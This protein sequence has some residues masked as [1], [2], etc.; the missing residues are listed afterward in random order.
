MTDLTIQQ[1]INLIKRDLDTVKNPRILEQILD[2]LGYGNKVADFHKEGERKY[3][4][5]LKV[6][7][8]LIISIGIT[9]CSTMPKELTLNIRYVNPEKTKKSEK[10]ILLNT[11]VREDRILLLAIEKRDGNIFDFAGLL[12]HYN[13]INEDPAPIG[14]LKYLKEGS[15]YYKSGG[16]FLDKWWTEVILTYNILLKIE[17]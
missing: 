11:F 1:A 4:T 17:E 7:L 3:M 5:I 8:L 2:I 16:S 9:G 13:S 14:F 6:G 15:L 10:E 12:N